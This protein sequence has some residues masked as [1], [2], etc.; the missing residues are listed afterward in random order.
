[1]SQALITVSFNGKGGVNAE[2][3]VVVQRIVLLG[4]VINHVVS[5]CGELFDQVLTRLKTCM[6]G[7]D[8][9]AQGVLLVIFRGAHS[10]DIYLCSEWWTGFPKCAR[11]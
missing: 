10:M 3:W 7:G 5:C 8:M 1:M 9:Y 2:T 6:V 11:R 4:P